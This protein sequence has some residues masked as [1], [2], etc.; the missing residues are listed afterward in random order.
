MYA[1]RT[2]DLI[3]DEA[4]SGQQAVVPLADLTLVAGGLNPQPEPPGR[5]L[6]AALPGLIPFQQ[7]R[8][9]AGGLNPQPLPPIARFRA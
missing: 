3:M 7:L 8:A 1:V 2:G 4:S 6:L 5:L 9:V